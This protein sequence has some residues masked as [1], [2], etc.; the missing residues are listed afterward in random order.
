MEEPGI[1][2]SQVAVDEG[3]QVIMSNRV[4]N[5]DRRTCRQGTLTPFKMFPMWDFSGREFLKTSCQ[6]R[7]FQEIKDG[8]G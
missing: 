4:Q 3:Q 6:Y 2:A 1:Q 5:E 7:E 8:V